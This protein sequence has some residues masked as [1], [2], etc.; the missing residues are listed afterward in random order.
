MKTQLTPHEKDLIRQVNRKHATNY[1]ARHLIA[2][3]TTSHGIKPY[4]V[5]NVVVYKIHSFYV[6]F[7]KTV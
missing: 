2:W 4:R 5:S 7:R 3:S 1:D 6:A